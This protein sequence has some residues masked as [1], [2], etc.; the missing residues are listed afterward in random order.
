VKATCGAK[1]CGYIADGCGGIVSCWGPTGVCP[2]G[3]TCGGAGSANMCGTDPTCTGLCLQQQG[4]PGAATTSIEGYVTSPNGVLPIPN[5]AVYVPNAALTAFVDGVDRTAGTCPLCAAASGSPLVATTTDANGHFLLPNMPVSTPGKVVDIPVVVQLGR[6]RKKFTIQTTACTN[7]LVPAVGASTYD[8]TAALPANKTQGDI[9]LTAISTGAVDGLECVIRKIGVDD[10][11]FTT[12]SGTGRIRL[13]QDNS[14]TAGSVPSRGACAPGCGP[15][16]NNADCSQSGAAACPLASA[17]YNPPAQNVNG[18]ITAITLAAP[19]VVTTSAAH[20][21]TSGQVVTI[22]G[23]RPGA[24]LGNI[25]NTSWLVT[26]IDATH[27]SLY[28][29]DTTGAG[30]YTGSGVWNGCNGAG[31]K[32]A[33]DGYDAVIFGCVGG[34]QNKP[35]NAQDNVIGYANVGGRVFATHFSYVWLY[36]VKPWQQTADAWNPGRQAWDGTIQTFLD[37]SFPK[38]VLFQNWLQAPVPPVS[39]SY[40][41]PYS[42]VNGLTT[43]SPPSITISEARKDI[44]PSAAAGATSGIVSPAQRWLYTTTASTVGGGSPAGQNAP[45]HYTFNTDTTKPAAQQCGRVLYSD[46]HVTT[47]ATTNLVF[48]NECSATF[49]A[50]EKVLAYMLF[51]LASCVSTSGPP[52][53]VKKSCADLGIGCGPAGDGCGGQ[54]DCG[55]C[56]LGQTCGGGGVPSQCGAPACTPAK[57]AMGMCGKLGDGCGGTLDCGACAT[58]TCGGGGPNVCGAAPCNPSSCPAP[59]LGSACGPVG[60]GCGGVNNCPCPAGVPCVNGTCGAPPCTPRT[61]AQAGANC[62]TI[63]DGCG[64]TIDCG[65]CV[66]PQTCGGGGVANLCGG[67]VN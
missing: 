64:K 26:V 36:N 62:G 1:N 7:T 53:C 15:G 50:Q 21:L 20:G 34:Q 18:N 23:V 32:P 59:A 42:P 67:G 66:A 41:P 11:E 47:G 56:P 13:Y 63:A 45:M 49:T 28:T 46:F 65:G 9:P 58:G 10:A 6:W 2:P 35:L 5:A 12:G 19:P 38:G 57:C 54:Q 44:E 16:G 22:T 51:D 29:G 33:I 48:P 43:V 14:F 31:C 40:A 37:T 39:A 24:T 55:N 25:V 30:A 27:F 60:N 61:C 52:A 8:H 4:C 3:Q 17:I